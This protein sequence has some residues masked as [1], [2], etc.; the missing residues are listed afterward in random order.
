[1]LCILSNTKDTASCILSTNMSMPIDF[2]S[3]MKGDY[4]TLIHKA[5]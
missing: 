1:M 2:I 5:I 4:H 3:D